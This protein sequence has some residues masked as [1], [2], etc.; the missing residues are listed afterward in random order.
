[1]LSGELVWCIRCGAYGDGK[2]IALRQPCTG[3]PKASWPDG[4]VVHH[5][6]GRAINLWL[7]KANRHPQP[8]LPI[9]TPVPEFNWSESLPLAGIQTAV[10]ANAAR[11]KPRDGI[12]TRIRQ[13]E[14]AAKELKMESKRKSSSTWKK[15]VKTNDL[16]P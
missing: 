3:N 13:K 15:R 2:A 9:P 8:R 7:L 11:P 1:M 16:T 4:K 10:I 12:L 5:T 14:A 6:T